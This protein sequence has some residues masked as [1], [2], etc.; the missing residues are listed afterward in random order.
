MRLTLKQY[1]QLKNFKDLDSKVLI[2]LA[3]LIANGNASLFKF[4]VEN[5]FQNNEEFNKYLEVLNSFEII[6]KKDFSFI[7][8]ALKLKI[9]DKED[10]LNEQTIEEITH[11]IIENLNK[12][13]GKK[14]RINQSRV[15][16]VSKWINKGYKKEDFYNVNL[17]Y[18]LLWLE[19]PNFNK[20]LRPET[21]YNNKFEVRVEEANEFFNLIEKY[22]EEINEIIN[23]YN[24]TYNRYIFAQNILLENK[25]AVEISLD[26]YYFYK[27]GRKILFW[28]S[29]K[30]DKEIIKKVIDISISNWSKKPELVP[31]I[32]L[33]KI[34]DEKFSQRVQFVQNKILS[35]KDKSIS[36]ISGWLKNKEEKK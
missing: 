28:L 26:D 27:K 35:V 11:F 15:S 32:T 6:T 7:T 21:L 4:F 12:I 13:T 1:K 19:D 23:F 22:K 18:A 3:L 2:E 25:N 14:Y 5:S 24:E 17:Y 10:T 33:E 36:S 20:Y 34:L 16:L 31:Y 29:K 8:K 30:Y 9:K